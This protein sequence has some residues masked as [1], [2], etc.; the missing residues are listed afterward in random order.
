MGVESRRYDDQIGRE[1]VEGRQ[2]HALEHGT[3]V[4]VA[5][6]GR[7][8]AVDREAGSCAVA[9]LVGGAGSRIEGKLVGR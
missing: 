7:Q 3:V 6:I 2:E 4:R 5:P 9:D 1:A 8:R